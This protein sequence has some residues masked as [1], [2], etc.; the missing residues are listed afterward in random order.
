MSK[1]YLW[2]LGL[3][4]ILT[5]LISFTAW[6]VPG[7]MSYQ[8]QL[9]DTTGN[10]VPD[11]DYEMSF[12]LYDAPT[13]GTALWS[14]AQ[15]VTV[16]NGIYTVILGQPENELDPA[17]F[18]GDLYLGVTVAPDSEMTPRQPL[19]SVGYALRA[20]VA[21]MVA[22]GAV[23]T[24]MLQDAAVDTTKLA[25]NAIT[26]SKLG[27]ATVTPAKIQ[28]GAT[29][30]EISDDD[31][32]GS[33]LDAD[34]VDG[35]HGSYYLNW[36]NLTNVPA[37]FADGVD[38]NSGGDI[39]SVSAGTGL[40]GGGASGSVTL[41]V[42]VPLALSGSSSGG[43]VS[44]TNSYAS[45]GSGVYGFASA[46]TGSNS[47]VYGRTASTSGKGV[48]G[49]ATATTGTTYGLRGDTVSTSGRGVYGLASAASGETYGVY[50]LSSSSDGRGVYGEAS[51]SE[52]T[53]VSGL[54]AGS[55]GTGVSGQA[56]E[57]GAFKKNR[58]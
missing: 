56:Y 52:G 36:N 57:T 42:D 18:V 53:G 13:G 20:Q 47:G 49:Y 51:G 54:A 45:G 2:T 37:G 35:Q 21:N 14:E 7:R 4:C 48:Y 28:D 44:A 6:A 17:D 32:A 33:G 25:D 23:T 1:R 30:S 50:G 8:G 58:G 40:N 5:T 38:N 15:T 3:A 26:E 29:L 19:T 9:T 43:V 31:G 22:N 34:M 46:T 16:I 39:T 27:D 41:N 55:E 24:M 10:P 11:G 12:A